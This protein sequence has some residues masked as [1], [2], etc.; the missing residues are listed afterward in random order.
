MAK[1]QRRYNQHEIKY[2]RKNN[3]PTVFSTAVRNFH[4]RTRQNNSIFSVIFILFIITFILCCYAGINP[5]N[6]Y[7]TVA[8]TMV[9]DNFNGPCILPKLN[10]YDPV[11]VQKG[12]K[13][14]PIECQRC[15]PLIYID[16]KNRLAFNKTYLIKSGISTNEITCKCNNVIRSDADNKIVWGETYSCKPPSDAKADFF[17]VICS[18]KGNVVYDNILTAILRKRTKSRAEDGQYNVY[19]VGI[20]SVSRPVAM[21]QLKK[22]L[23]YMNDELNAFHF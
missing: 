23:Q 9:H 21:R 2:T 1:Y 20:D 7:F 14:N 17:K 8:V 16:K 13:Y 6:D 12:N 19:M 3:M 4:S 15:E 11:M 18:R 5:I 22:T 10:P